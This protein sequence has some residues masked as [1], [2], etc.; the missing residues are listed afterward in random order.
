MLGLYLT[1]LETLHVLVLHQL[2]VIVLPSAAEMTAQCTVTVVV[3]VILEMTAQ[4]GIIA[5]VTL[6]MT[7]QIG[8]MTLIVVDMT[9]QISI[10]FDTNRRT[11]VYGGIMNV[12]AVET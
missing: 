8:I 11:T 3:V 12:V 6:E 10:M 1:L 9:A 2:T 7:A 4:I 5:V